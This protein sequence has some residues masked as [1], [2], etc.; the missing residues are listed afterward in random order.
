M[1][2]RLLVVLIVLLLT[3]P[4]FAFAKPVPPAELM[5]LFTL[6]IHVEEFVEKNSWDDADR[7]ATAI[8]KKYQDLKPLLA[9]DVAAPRLASFDRLQNSFVKAVAAR[10]H[11]SAHVS[12]IALHKAFLDLIECFD[13]RISPLLYVV[14]NDLKEAAEALRTE[15]FEEFADELKEVDDYYVRA[16][17]EL[18]KWNVSRQS[19]DEFRGLVAKV[20]I[21]YAARDIKSVKATVGLMQQVFARQLKLVS[22]R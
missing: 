20:K 12:F 4:S 6:F 14:Q 11:E 19:L 13:Y 21:D 8:V 10:H 1:F 16:M 15:N 2:S 9:K 3:C 22:R 17:P 5:K 7:W 18:L